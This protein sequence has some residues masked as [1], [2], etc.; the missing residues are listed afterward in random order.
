MTKTSLRIVAVTSALVLC[1]LLIFNLNNERWTE[2]STI[3]PLYADMQL[4]QQKY[5]TAKKNHDFYQ[6]TDEQ[7]ATSEAKDAEFAPKAYQA[8]VNEWKSVTDKPIEEP[9]ISQYI[10]ASFL[11]VIIAIL[12]CL[13]FLF[14]FLTLIEKQD[15]PEN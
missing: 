8:D 4:Q 3:S 1:W 6:A 15:M 13:L 12:C 2:Y 7:M 11:T 10:K 5:E 9:D 14:I